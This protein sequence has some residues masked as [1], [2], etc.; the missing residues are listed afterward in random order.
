MQIV[1]IKLR[2]R[3]KDLK[4]QGWSLVYSKFFFFFEWQA[5]LKNFDSSNQKEEHTTYSQA[6]P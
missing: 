3:K 5:Y 2:A 6:I 1:Q 4:N